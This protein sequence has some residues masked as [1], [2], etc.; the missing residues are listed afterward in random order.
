MVKKMLA[1]LDGT[2]VDPAQPI[3]R[4]DDEGVLRGDGVFEALLVVEAQMRDLDA[5]LAR[6]AVSA[7]MLE[8]PDPDEAG[9]R[10]AGEALVGRWDWHAEREATLRFVWTRGPEGA[11]RPNAWAL[12]SPLDEVTRRQ[13]ATGVQ[14]LLLD[15]GFEPEQVESL[16]WLLPGAKSLSYAINMAAKRHAHQQGAD[17]VVFCSPS[18]KLLEG[19]TCSV[20]LDIDGVL[21]TPPVE[22]VLRSITV[23]TLARQAPAAGLELCFSPL[24]RSDF[25]RCRGAWLLSS[26]RILSRITQADGDRLPA[27]LL[28]STLKRVLGVPSV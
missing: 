28:D 13:R 15:R 7:A 9:F 11:G 12:L 25:A 8:L 10:R 23:Q 19:P 21:H 4:A 27:S 3:V 26:T 2:L 24:E 6:L 17:D 18:G 14:V 1:L 22:G 5:H 20:V 16:P